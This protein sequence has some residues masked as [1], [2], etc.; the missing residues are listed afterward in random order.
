M[1]N[2][3]HLM[4]RLSRVSTT[5]LLAALLIGIPTKL[6]S[7]SG[8]QTPVENSQAE[9]VD[10]LFQAGIE[11]FQQGEF[12]TAI[13]I[14]QQVLQIRTSSGD[15]R[16]EAE[17]LTR[18]GQ[19]YLSLSRYQTALEN[20]ETALSIHQ[21]VNNRVGEGE[22]LNHLG[23]VYRK[24]ADYFKAE[25]YHQQALTIA[26]EIR[27]RPME[28]EALHNLAAV[29]AAYEEY[30]PALELY[31]QALRIRREVGEQ[32]PIGRTLNNLGSIYDRLGNYQAA[33]NY[34]QEALAIFQEINDRPGVG[35]ILSNLGLL[36]R[37]LGNDDRAIAHFEAAL[38]I[39]EEIGDR[40]ITGRTLNSLGVLYENQ[41]SYTKSLEAYQ[42]FLEIAQNLD[43]P[44][45]IGNAQENL[46]GIYS[47][48]GRY[49]PALAFYHQS[50]NIR[51]EIRDRAGIA[52]SLNNIG[53]LYHILGRSDRAL[54]FLKKS[55]VLQIQLQE[56][57]GEAATLNSIGMVYDSQQNYQE[58]EKVYQDAL[59][60]ARQVG[61]ELAIGQNLENLGLVY[62][63]LGEY[64]TAGQVYQ[65]ALEILDRLGNQG[66]IGTIKNH[67]GALYLAQ[68]NN[69]KALELLHE[70]LTIFKKIKDPSQEA[71]ALSNVSQVLA[72]K[73]QLEM[74]ILFAKQAVNLI[75]EIRRE[76]RSGSEGYAPLPLEE[77]QS[78]TNTVADIYRHLADLL[79]QQDRVEE[80]HQVL[81]LLKVHEIDQHLRNVQSN[82]AAEIQVELHP[83]EQ[84][85]LTEYE[86]LHTEA[87]ALGQELETLQAIPPSQRSPEQQQR[88]TEI[89]KLQQEQRVKF[90]QFILRSD[91]V[92]MSQQLQRNTAGESL[93]LTMLNRLRTTLQGLDRNAVVFYPLILDDRLELV[94]VTANSPPIH[95]S[96]LVSKQEF[97]QAI[98]DFRDALT[99]PR[100]RRRINRVK[101]AGQKLYNLLIQPI[102]EDLAMAG[103][104][105]ILYAPDGQLRYVPLSALYDGSQWAIERWAVNN[106]TAASLSNFATDRINSPVAILAGAFS[107]GKYRFQAGETQYDFSG[108]PFAGEEVET[109]EKIIPETTPLFNTQFSSESIQTQINSHHYNVLHFATHAAFVNGEPEESFILFGNGDRLTLRDVESWSLPDIKLVVLSAC[110]TGVGSVFG[111]GKEILGFGYQMQKIGARVS[112]ASLWSVD[113]RATQV[114][115][116]NFY[117]TIHRHPNMSMAESLQRSQ[118]L[119]LDSDYQHP[120]YWSG[121]ILIGNGL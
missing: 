1:S 86:S 50:L 65:E 120:Y 24:L 14:Y 97:N 37:Q 60:I 95:R 81:D 77:R 19:A 47:H 11:Q 62:T 76:L 39:L 4:H 42:K 98:L 21:A 55:L 70:A 111:D 54:E 78:F 80:A 3:M 25:E 15:R 110:Q 101:V 64:Q 96:V 83:Q 88:L 29:R 103:T 69:D 71:I 27:N 75:E 104:K 66:G 34:Y 22:T 8:A 63:Q 23:Y 100:R 6:I 115:M 82:N 68:G 99:N 102:E 32:R 116:N 5:L 52:K 105:T 44:V 84:K 94:L 28:G 107:E 40:E 36:E 45:A 106:V 31:Q 58:A 72:E 33:R 57:A 114:L 91:V 53:G 61:D 112:L 17:T 51:E 93:D 109:I 92:E 118:M 49:I 18:L 13:K 20:L 7:R 74:A 46:G 79:L 9:E 2:L 67:L 56:K 43:D 117:T 87:I 35:R 90:N 113:D 10:R 108:L 59:E 48:L 119:L 16:G 85:I 73:N 26:R 30:Q 12:F 121:F 41:G 38:P 89:L